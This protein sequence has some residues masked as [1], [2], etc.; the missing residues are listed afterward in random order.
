MNIKP[1]IYEVKNL[2]IKHYLSSVGMKP[3]RIQHGKAW[4]RSP[5]G[6]KEVEKTAS[7]MVD[8]NK[9]RFTDFGTGLSGDILDLV[10]ALNHVNTATAIN[11][12][13]SANIS[14]FSGIQSSPEEGKSLE[15]LETKTISHPK[16]IY[17]INE[18]RIPLAIARSY[19]REIHYIN[20]GKR[21]FSLGF[22]NDKGGWEIRSNQFKGCVSPK[23]TTTIKGDTNA[24]N[25]FEGFFDFLSCLA[26]YHSQEL[27]NQ[28]IILNS[29][30][31]YRFI[32][33][34]LHNY[35]VINLFLD[36][37][38]AGKKLTA[39]IKELHPNAIDIS[40]SLYPE[41]NDFNDFLLGKKSPP[42]T[43]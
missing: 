27:K 25:I 7:L 26:F 5:M 31:N 43:N 14:S 40:K 20:K 19:C 21:F 24:L 38:E 32:E 34:N 22:K 2:S 37:D 36:N 6:R 8:L 4:Y 23:Y 42:S 33:R 12:L 9:N 3:D 13:S 15:V 16:L 41:H 11:M 17:Y 10:C 1:T 39:T 30:V 28:T 35:Q 18:R 29:L